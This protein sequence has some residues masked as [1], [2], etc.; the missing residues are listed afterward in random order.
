MSVKDLGQLFAVE[1]RAKGVKENFV[2][3]SLYI[4]TYSAGLSRDSFRKRQTS[5]RGVDTVASLK[6]SRCA[7]HGD[8][9][10]F[11]H[12]DQCCFSP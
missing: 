3:A 4:I 9:F 6:R 12:R 7:R 10:A 1:K 5:P 2:R 8:L 11:L